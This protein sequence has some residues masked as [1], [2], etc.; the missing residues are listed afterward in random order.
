MRDDDEFQS[1]D[2]S[3][4]KIPQGVE[5]FE[6]YGSLFFGAVAQFRES[7]RVIGKKPKVLILRMRNVSNVDASGLHILEELAREGSE[8]G[9]IIVFS[10]V[11]RSVYRV[12]RKSGFVETVGRDKFAGDVFAALEIATRHLQK[13]ER[14]ETPRFR[15]E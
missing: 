2:M 1:R 6:V 8:N 7:I 12:M 10:A 13:L 14:R 11:S 5:V 3:Q 4:I 9:Y 15:E